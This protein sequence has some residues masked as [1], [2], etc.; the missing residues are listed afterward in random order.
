MSGIKKSSSSVAERLETLAELYRRGEASALMERTL[1]KLLAHE[2]EQ[3]REQL[4]QLLADLARLEE[5]YGLSSAEFYR[6]F[7]AGETDDRMDYIE[8]A[9]LV[10]MRD[11]LQKRLELLSG[12]SKA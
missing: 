9:S 1:D 12:T 2:A 10:Q 3:G 6:R 8:W 4:D 11:N 7:Q 5:K